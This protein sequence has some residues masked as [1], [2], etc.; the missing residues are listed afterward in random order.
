VVA[1]KRRRPVTPTMAK[2]DR[3][4]LSDAAVRVIVPLEKIRKLYDSLGLLINIHS[5]DGKT[6][7]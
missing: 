5:S 7:R 2:A 6:D 3:T 4:P 1:P